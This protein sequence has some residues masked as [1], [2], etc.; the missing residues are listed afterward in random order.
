MQS[1]RSL[2]TASLFTDNKHVDELDPT[3]TKA[4]I[5]SI[6]VFLMLKQ[7]MDSSI[8]LSLSAKIGKDSREPID[9]YFA[10]YPGEPTEQWI[11]RDGSKCLTDLAG[12]YCAVFRIK[13]VTIHLLKHLH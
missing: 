7:K 9:K 13:K 5:L 6:K 1:A 8:Y 11:S 2:G 3:Q 4:F 12:R 10:F